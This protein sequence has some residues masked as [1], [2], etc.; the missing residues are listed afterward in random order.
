MNSVSQSID[1]ALTSH[2]SA[3]I[4]V[5]GDFNLNHKEWL[6]SNRTDTAGTH[7]YNFALSQSLHQTVDFVTRIPDRVDHSPS[8]FLPQTQPSVKHHLRLH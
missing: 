4:F 1:S 6:N 2:P 8:R 7:V 3:N 5:F